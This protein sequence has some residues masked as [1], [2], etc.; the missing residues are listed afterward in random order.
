MCFWQPRGRQTTVPL[1]A[2]EQKT[3]QTYLGEKLSAVLH[4]LRSQTKNQESCCLWKGADRGRFCGLSGFRATG[5]NP[6]VR[7][8]V[9]R[10]LGPAKSG[11][12]VCLFFR[13]E[14]ME[15]GTGPLVTLVG[16]SLKP[17]VQFPSGRVTC[18]VLFKTE[19]PGCDLHLSDLQGSVRVGEGW[20]PLAGDR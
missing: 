20:F 6:G 15:P 5:P 3:K 19:S 11:G 14:G 7:A 13:G 1:P 2:G 10:R 12:L 16:S 8:P 18:G 4:S 17:H 9:L